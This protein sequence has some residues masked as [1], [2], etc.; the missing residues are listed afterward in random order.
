MITSGLLI[1]TIPEKLEEV[2]KE[3]CN[4]NAVKFNG[5]ADECKMVVMVE[6]DSIDEASIIAR[7]IGKIDGVTGI[8]RAYYHVDGQRE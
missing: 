2:K 8:D 7:T 5:F 1:N 6:S 3:I 4:M